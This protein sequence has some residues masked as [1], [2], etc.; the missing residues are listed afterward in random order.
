MIPKMCLDCYAIVIQ[1]ILMYSWQAYRDLN[2]LTMQ[3]CTDDGTAGEA[4]KGT[5]SQEMGEY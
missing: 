2:C 4:D 1:C 5:G 3:N